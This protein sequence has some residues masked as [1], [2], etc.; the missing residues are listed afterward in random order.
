MTI[1]K[2]KWATKK[3]C[4]ESCKIY[5]EIGLCV[6]GRRPGARERGFGLSKL[7]GGLCMG[8]RH[9]CQYEGHA[10]YWRVGVR[11]ET[12]DFHIDWK[13]NNV[14]LNSHKFAQMSVACVQIVNFC[15]LCALFLG[16]KSVST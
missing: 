16:G 8:T 10:P 13:A 2:L 4:G 3:I 7:S 6:K 12:S 5:G 11:G 15:F 14:A 9:A 1:E